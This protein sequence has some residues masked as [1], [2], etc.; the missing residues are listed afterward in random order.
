[1]RI[2]L[3][4]KVRRGNVKA[5]EHLY[6]YFAFLFSPVLLCFF[7]IQIFMVS[8]IWISPVQYDTW[9]EEFFDQKKNERIAQ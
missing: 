4:I 9:K 3:V 8:V 6:Y 2:F 7:V 1:M 5:K